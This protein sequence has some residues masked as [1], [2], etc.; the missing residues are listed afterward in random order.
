MNKKG[1]KEDIRREKEKLK[2][3]NERKGN[4]IQ[5]DKRGSRGEESL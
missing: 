4:R 3:E 2:K 5:D 1:R